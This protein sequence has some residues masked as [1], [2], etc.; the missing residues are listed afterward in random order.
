MPKEKNVI[1]DKAG[2]RERLR[3]RFIESGFTGFHDYE[4]IE[5]LLAYALP[6]K[7]TKPIAKR[8]I[9]KFKSLPGVLSAEQKELESI[10]GVKDKT[11]LFLKVL[12]E[13]ISYYFEQKAQHEEICFTELNELIDYFRATIGGKKNEVVRV[14]YLNSQNKLIRAENLSEGTVSEAVAFPRKIVEGA[15]KNHA[16][17]VIMAHN[18]PGGIAEPSENDD[19]MTEQIK[20]ALQTID[21]SLQE[22]LI[23]TDNSY[24]YYKAGA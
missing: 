18:H 5:L 14:L 20:A 15:L 8:L 19:S 3:K 16:T 9:E 10:K 17:T 11:S 23:I 7:D 2:H 6:Y 4:V 13:N 24:L 12:N 22:H 21:V 1:K